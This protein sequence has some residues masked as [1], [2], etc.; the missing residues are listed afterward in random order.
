MVE[1]VSSNT[2]IVVRRCSQVPQNSTLLWDTILPMILS[3]IWS[4]TVLVAQITIWTAQLLW[5]LTRVAAAIVF[6]LV[7]RN[8][9][10]HKAPTHPASSLTI[11]GNTSTLRSGVA[12]SSRRSALVQ[13]LLKKKKSMSKILVQQE[14][15]SFSTERS[16]ATETSTSTSSSSDVASDREDPT[17]T[18]KEMTPQ[19]NDGIHDNTHMTLTKRNRRLVVP[20]TGGSSH[21]N[22]IHAMPGTASS[23]RSLWRHHF[24]QQR[25]SQ[26]QQH[27]DPEQHPEILRRP[28]RGSSLLERVASNS[29]RWIS[30][31]TSSTRKVR[32]LSRTK[33]AVSPTRMCRRSSR[34]S[35]TCQDLLLQQMDECPEVHPLDTSHN[36]NFAWWN[37]Q[38]PNTCSTQNDD[39]G[40]SVP[41]ISTSSSSLGSLRPE[42]QRPSPAGVME[43]VVFDHGD[44]TTTDDVVASRRPQR[45]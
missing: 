13:D 24:K 2:P 18:R 14:E 42:R 9:P 39:D 1:D 27:Y 38:A 12:P 4:G 21:H 31:S 35:S 6:Q 16:I 7:M 41:W 32:S 29:A 43:I 45:R 11:S 36:T 25:Q 40:R 26:E 30:P 3:T 8:K 10:L 37:N 34:L 17:K 44:T 22:T 20:V 33:A 19:D 15:A 5:M 28:I 23:S